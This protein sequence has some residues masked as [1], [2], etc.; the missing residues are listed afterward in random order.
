[1]KISLFFDTSGLVCLFKSI[2][3]FFFVLGVHP[4]SYK[5]EL[6]HDPQIKAKLKLSFSF[7]RQPEPGPHKKRPLHEYIKTNLNRGEITL[8]VSEMDYLKEHPEDVQWL[9]EDRKSVV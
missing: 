8:F 5:S 6:A 3:D 9:K 1:M 7:T 4:D 2:W